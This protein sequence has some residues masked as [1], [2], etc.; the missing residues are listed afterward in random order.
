MMAVSV[1]D[2]IPI[3]QDFL[4]RLRPQPSFLI[5]HDPGR[6]VTESY[7]GTIKYPETY[8][9]SS[10]GKLLKKYEGAIDWTDPAVVAE[11]E[12]FLDAAAL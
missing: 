10:E 2:N 8:L 9:I 12:G 6:L 4:G 5:L 1:D 7:Y 3:I 11:I